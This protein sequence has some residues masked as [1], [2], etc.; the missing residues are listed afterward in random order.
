M[1]HK[2]FEDK[3]LSETVSIL[4]HYNSY[5][6]YNLSM[7]KMKTKNAIQEEAKNVSQCEYLPCIRAV[8][9]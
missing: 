2:E 1:L 3:I 5:K 4:G 7:G 8:Y 6:K 9:K